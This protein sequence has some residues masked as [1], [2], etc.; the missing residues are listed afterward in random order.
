MAETTYTISPT[1][2]SQPRTYLVM[3]FEH[4]LVTGRHLVLFFCLIGFKSKLI[5][6]LFLSRQLSLGIRR[7]RHRSDLIIIIVIFSTS[8]CF[9][10]FDRWF[11]FGSWRL[12]VSSGH[13]PNVPLLFVCSS[14]A[15]LSY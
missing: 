14:Q 10:S 1:N 8:G 6:L 7:R 15:W 3:I 11:L 4:N 9:F 13:K 5:L 12:D 2:K